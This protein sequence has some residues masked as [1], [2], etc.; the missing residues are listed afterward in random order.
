MRDISDE[1][2]GL[3]YGE[4]AYI[5]GLDDEELQELEDDCY[6]A[7]EEQDTR[8]VGDYITEIEFERERRMGL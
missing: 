3:S 1:N 4:L 8:L 5:Q 2:R 7:Q 6:K